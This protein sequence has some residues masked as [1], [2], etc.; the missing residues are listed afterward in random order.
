M[1]YNWLLIFA[2][3]IENKINR[4]GFFKSPKLQRHPA[5]SSVAFVFQ[6]TDREY[7]FCTVHEPR[8]NEV[9]GDRPNS[10][11]N[12]TVRY[13]EVLFSYILLL[14]GQRIPFVISRFS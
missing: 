3:L 9:A 8:F 6:S 12:S 7:N 1:S 11:V 14:L 10:F 2:F 5:T 13:I 4:Y